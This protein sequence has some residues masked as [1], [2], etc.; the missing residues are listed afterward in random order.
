MPQPVLNVSV[1]VRVRHQRH[2]IG[3][4]S[5]RARGVLGVQQ[6]VAGAALGL[7]PALALGAARVG[8]YARAAAPGPA[9]ATGAVAAPAARRREHGGDD[10]AVVGVAD[11]HA[12]VQ[13]QVGDAG[14]AV[15]PHEVGVQR[16]VHELEVRN[17]HGRAQELLEERRREPRSPQGDAL[18]QRLADD[19]AG[20]LVHAQEVARHAAAVARA[21]VHR[22][23]ALGSAEEPR[24]RRRRRPPRR[25]A[26]GAAGLPRHAQPEQRLRR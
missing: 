10:L 5:L 24:V 11:L 23:A 3:V 19:A 6:R 16:R 12:K 13:A 26:P 14:V 7:G 9:G 22:A 1:L 4:R 25:P 17:A 15:Q 18:Q 20:E 8:V 21:D 2:R